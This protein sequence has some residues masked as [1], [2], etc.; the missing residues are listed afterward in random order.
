IYA[1]DAFDQSLPYGNPES[2]LQ[3]GWKLLVPPRPIAAHTT[4]ALP[5]PPTSYRYYLLWITALPPS[6]SSAEIAE[7]TL[8]R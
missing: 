3:R 5:S 6:A 8:F 4:L 2:L 1:A 7:I